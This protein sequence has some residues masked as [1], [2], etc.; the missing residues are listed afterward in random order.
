M[1]AAALEDQQP[2]NNKK[3]TRKECSQKLISNIAKIGTDFFPKQWYKL[4]QNLTYLQSKTTVSST[5]HLKC[6]VGI[7]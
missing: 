1:G 7:N 6:I 2:N 5:R 4:K 3:N